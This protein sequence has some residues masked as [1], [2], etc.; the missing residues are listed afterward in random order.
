[1]DLKIARDSEAIEEGGN[2]LLNLQKLCRGLSTV[3]GNGIGSQ[4]KFNLV[5]Q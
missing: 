3:T 1:M 2:E 5:S 4:D